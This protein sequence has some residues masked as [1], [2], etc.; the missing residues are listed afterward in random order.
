MKHPLSVFKD[1]PEINPGFTVSLAIT[2]TKNHEDYQFLSRNLA[3][4]IDKRIVFGSDGEPAMLKGMEDALPIENVPA[5]ACNIGLRCF[6]HV[7][8]NI[9]KHLGGYLGAHEVTEIVREVL[10]LEYGGKR[11][12][13]L[14]DSVDVETF[15]MNY[16]RLKLTWPEK[17]IKF[18]EDRK[19]KHRTLVDAFKL[20]MLKPVRIAAGLGDPPNKY[21]NNLN[22]SLNLVVQE[23]NNR[24]F[25]D[26]FPFIENVKTRVFEYQLEEFTKALYG[27]G[28]YRLSELGLQRLPEGRITPH[29]WTFGMNQSQRHT[30]FNKVFKNVGGADQIS[31][32]ITMPSTDMKLSV[33]LERCSLNS[34]FTISTIKDIWAKAEFI[35]GNGEI[36][37]MLSGSWCVQDF[38]SASVVTKEESVS[39]VLYRCNCAAFLSI[40]LSCQFIFLHAVAVA[41]YR[42][43]FIIKQ[44]FRFYFIHPHVF[45]RKLENV[46]SRCRLLYHLT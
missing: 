24:N 2:P 40:Y 43:R 18:L 31:R 46:R 10:G 13:G 14:V 6:T 32:A 25:V 39:G 38:D 22:E 26:V 36:S 37:K 41:S 20:N 3:S 33:P 45:V 21:V 12:E 5:E 16:R 15:E 9:E 19:G 44:I 29:V 30:I 35:L 11:L 34:R 23:A 8:D 28:E 4:Y 27:F 17:F 42:R 1:K 7:Q